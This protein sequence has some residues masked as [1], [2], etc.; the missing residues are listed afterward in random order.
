MIL[1]SSTG[2]KHLHPTQGRPKQRL[3]KDLL[4]ALRDLRAEV[5][6][7]IYDLE[8]SFTNNGTERYIRML[9]VKLKISG[10]F[11]RIHAAKRFLKVCSTI[12]TAREQGARI[13][14]V[15][16]FPVVGP[17]W[18]LIDLAPAMA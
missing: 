13:V 15:W 12:S 9:K 2:T 3:G 14:G 4:D 6:R 1:T 5:L 17:V 7:F 11:R 8:V 18:I 16:I 10:R